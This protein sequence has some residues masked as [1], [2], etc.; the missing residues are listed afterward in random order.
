MLPHKLKNFRVY[1]DGD[2]YAGVAAELALPKIA[3]SGDDYR[4][5]GMLGPVQT[6]MG[7]DKLEQEETYGGIVPK[8]AAALGNPA[9][10]GTMT[11]FVGAYQADDTGAVKAAELVVRGRLMELDPGNAKAGGDTEWKV[12]RSLTYLKWIVDGAVLI[13]IDLIGMIFVVNGVDRMAEI[14]AVLEG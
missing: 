9:A 5:A 12:K 6:D 11:R 1:A 10:D 7:L 8:I 2:N 14:R 13:E 4:G 3:I